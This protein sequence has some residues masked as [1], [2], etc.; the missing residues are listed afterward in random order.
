MHLFVVSN[1]YPLTLPTSLTTSFCDLRQHQ[2]LILFLFPTAT[3]AE[4]EREKA[5]QPRCCHEWGSPY[6]WN[7]ALFTLGSPRFLVL[8]VVFHRV[9]QIFVLYFSSRP[10]LTL[11]P[12]LDFQFQL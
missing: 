8:Q 11:L 10:L 2:C 4:G 7:L 5:T 12:T 3:R 6:W 1:E 9:P